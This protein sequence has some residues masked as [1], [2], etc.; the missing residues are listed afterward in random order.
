[1]ADLALPA[2]ADVAV[3]VA[4]RTKTRTATDRKAKVHMIGPLEKQLARQT[5][6]AAVDR[7]AESMRIQLA[8]QDV[9]LSS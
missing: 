8:V 3:D 7:L 4:N 6:Q 9:S 1:V 5:K 2:A